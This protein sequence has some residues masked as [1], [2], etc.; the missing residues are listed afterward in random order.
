M[1]ASGVSDV[2]GY[3][4]ARGRC[5]GRGRRARVERGV[6]RDYAE[7]H[8]YLELAAN[9]G[10]SVA[11]SSLGYLY[12]GGFGVAQDYT[13]AAH[14]Y[15]L[16]A[17]SGYALGQHNLA[18]MFF[19]GQGVRQSYQKALYWFEKAAQQGH[20][21]ARIDFGFLLMNGLGTAKDPVA[22]YAWILA[23]SNAGDHHGDDYL[24]ALRTTLDQQKLEQATQQAQSLNGATFPAGVLLLWPETRATPALY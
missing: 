9:A 1:S 13:Q 24:S 6:R 19:R 16:A 22:A 15:R 23:A 5:A 7:A 3:T 12:D 20:T 8:K 14:W 18:V 10:D 17:E 11:Q 4:P 2:A 21:A